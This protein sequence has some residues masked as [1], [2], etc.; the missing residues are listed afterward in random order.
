M[1]VKT[2]C[3]RKWERIVYKLLVYVC[4]QHTVRV[5][6]LWS[7]CVLMSLAHM[8][9]GSTSHSLQMID[10]LKFCCGSWRCHCCVKV[11]VTVCMR[12][13]VKAWSLLQRQHLLSHSSPY[14][15]MRDCWKLQTYVSVSRLRTDPGK[16]WKVMEF[17][18][19]IFQFWKVLE[20]GKSWKINQVVAT[21]IDP[22][23]PK[24]IWQLSST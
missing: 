15:R 21:F 16:S 18:I 9:R 17:R 6:H 20:S 12:L 7:V 22:C 5:V 8:Y 3:V 10:L 4:R 19:Q 14:F 24:P 1:P 2:V 11:P 23:T 13:S